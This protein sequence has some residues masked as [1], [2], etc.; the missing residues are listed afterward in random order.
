MLEL[1]LSTW[2]AGCGRITKR[3]TDVSCHYR[4]KG[5]TNFTTVAFAPVRKQDDWQV[6]EC[7]LPAFTN[8]GEEVQYF[9]DM[10]FDG[11]YN[12]RDM[13]SVRVQ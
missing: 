2:G 5:E 9:I 1:K 11:V 6:Y 7:T 8:A 3:Y 12:K 13:V 4:F 10:S